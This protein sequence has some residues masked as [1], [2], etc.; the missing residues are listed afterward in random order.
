MTFHDNKR[1]ESD[2][3]DFLYALLMDSQCYDG[4]SY[5]EFCKC[6]GYDMYEEKS[7]YPYVGKC[8]K[9]YAI[10]K[11]CERQYKKLHKLFNNEEIVELEKLLENY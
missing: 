11:A 9:S 1:N 8:K 6:F 3:V 4:Y 7:Y 10:Y 2:K 5:E